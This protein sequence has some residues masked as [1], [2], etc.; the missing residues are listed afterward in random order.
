[1]FTERTNAPIKQTDNF[2][3]DP[4]PELSSFRPQAADPQGVPRL[5]VTEVRP[6]TGMSTPIKRNQSPELVE[7]PIYARTLHLV[8]THVSVYKKVHGD[9]WRRNSLC[10][11]CFRRH[12]NFRKLDE[13]GYEVCGHDEAL[14]SHYWEARE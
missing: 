2:P 10:L 12:G 9:E 14:E 11:Y 13:H 6:S 7:T 4:L 1:M 5:S 3:S 8:D